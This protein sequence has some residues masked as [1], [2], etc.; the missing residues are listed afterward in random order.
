M[1]AARRKGSRPGCLGALA[2]ILTCAA[3]RGGRNRGAA[4]RKTATTPAAGVSP[5]KEPQQT[6]P[7]RGAPAAGAPAGVSP[8]RDPRNLSPLNMSKSGKR[9]AGNPQ[10]PAQNDFMTSNPVYGS[11]TPATPATP[12]SGGRSPGH[13]LFQKQQQKGVAPICFKTGLLVCKDLLV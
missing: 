2:G 5:M 3:C 8:T 1:E 7:N 6:T 4:A 11:Q 13:R 9:E 12:A 10:A